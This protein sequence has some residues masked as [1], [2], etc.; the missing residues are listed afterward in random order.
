MLSS[1]GSHRRKALPWYI[2]S[3]S[4]TSAELPIV[5]G[6]IRPNFGRTA[7]RHVQVQRRTT[8]AYPTVA[9]AM[10][11][12]EFPILETHL[13]GMTAPSKDDFGQQ[14]APLTIFPCHLGFKG[15]PC[16]PAHFRSCQA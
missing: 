15:S 1:L 2:L 9:D 6:R 10:I 11:E 13:N 8:V 16:R 4:S 12:T 7:H 3:A 5:Y 14:G